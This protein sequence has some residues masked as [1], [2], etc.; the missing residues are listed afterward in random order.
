LRFNRTGRSVVIREARS[1]IAAVN[2]DLSPKLTV[3]IGCRL[4]Y[5]AVNPTPMLLIIRPRSS[6]TQLIASER[7]SITPYSAYEEV[8]DW[9]GNTIER[10]ELPPGQTTI[11]NDALIEVPTAPDD[12]NRRTNSVFVRQLPA[13]VLRYLL[14]SRYCD[15]DKTQQF[16]SNQFGGIINGVDRVIAISNWVHH[17]IQYVTGSGRPD[18]PRPRSWRGY[19][20]CR[21]FAHVAIA[22]CRSVNIPARYVTGHL[23]DIGVWDPGSPMDFHAYVEVY[24]DG[25][26]CAFD[27]RYNIPRIGRVKIAHGLDAADCA[28][29]TTFGDAQLLSIEVW[30]YQVNSALVAVGDPVDLSKRLDGTP[31]IRCF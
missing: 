28:F 3:R 12:Y 21:D 27:A 5:Q 25:E 10:W 11:T 13:S 26:W 4:V 18:F 19:G 6:E 15:S 14:P 17:N 24:L 8:R 20:V 23:P 2:V 31:Q 16:A 1:A 9:M 22:L 7:L 29:S 30:A